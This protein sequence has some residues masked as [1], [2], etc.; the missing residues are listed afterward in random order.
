MVNAGQL[1]HAGPVS[2]DDIDAGTYEDAELRDRARR[3]DMIAVRGLARL[4]AIRHSVV[5]RESDL[6][7]VEEAAEEYGSGQVAEETSQ[8]SHLQPR[9]RHRWR[10][11]TLLMSW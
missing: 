10:R 2:V 7:L 6:I 8:A 1:L 4:K 3:N 11:W 9:R 5:R